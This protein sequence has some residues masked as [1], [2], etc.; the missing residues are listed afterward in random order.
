MAPFVL[1]LDGACMSVAYKQST[2]Q[3]KFVHASRKRARG[4]PRGIVVR[5]PA[6]NVARHV[7]AANAASGSFASI[8]LFHGKSYGASS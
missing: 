3:C 7:C 4:A 1:V 2:I 8:S 6:S 5:P